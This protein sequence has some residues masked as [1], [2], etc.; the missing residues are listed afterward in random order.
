MEDI[1]TSLGASLGPA[2]ER[3]GISLKGVKTSMSASLG[4]LPTALIPP[5]PLRPIPSHISKGQHAASSQNPGEKN[6]T[7]IVENFSGKIFRATSAD[8]VLLARTNG[9]TAS[10]SHC[11]RQYKTSAEFSGEAEPVGGSAEAVD[12]GSTENTWIM[13]G[14]GRAAAKAREAAG[15]AMQG[16][17][18][19]LEGVAAAGGEFGRLGGVST[20]E[21]GSECRKQLHDLRWGLA[22]GAMENV[23][24]ARIVRALKDTRDELQSLCKERETA[25]A[26]LHERQQ[27]LSKRLQVIEVAQ[28]F[29]TAQ[30]CRCAVQ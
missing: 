24:L 13:F 8:S 18:G 6:R 26:L 1:T 30:R 25:L 21:T 17:L 5:G 3:L 11:A 15:A 23:E 28:E 27:E 12:E 10:S 22:S 4:A 2:T 29:R 16:G 9:K 19:I 20:S 7:T 14:L